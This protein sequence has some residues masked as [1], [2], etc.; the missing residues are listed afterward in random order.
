L[1]PGDYRRKMQPP[2]IVRA[3]EGDRPPRAAAQRRT[4]Q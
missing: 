1:S 3:L 2:G 4:M